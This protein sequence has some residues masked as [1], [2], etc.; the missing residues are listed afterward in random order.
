M[1]ARN[2]FVGAITGLR[3]GVSFE[4][5]LRLDDASELVAVI[6][7]AS[8]ENLELTI[9]RSYADEGAVGAHH[10]R[11]GRAAPPPQPPVGHGVGDHEDR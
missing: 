11:P 4:V 8:A 2:Q 1:P 5:R 7:R 10:H 9:G 6:T 3:G